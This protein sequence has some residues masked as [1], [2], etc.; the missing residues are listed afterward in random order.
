MMGMRVIIKDAQEQR[1]T[2]RDV[3]GPWE[4]PKVPSK[5]RGRKG[6]RRAWKRSHPPHHIML[7]REPD[8]VLVLA[9]QAIIATPHQADYLRRATQLRA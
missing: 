9:G 3:K 1:R 6:T 2:A 8:D 7:Y 4:R 5:R